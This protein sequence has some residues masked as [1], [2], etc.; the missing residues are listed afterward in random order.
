MPTLSWS[1]DFCGERFP[2]EAAAQWHEY[3]QCR[4]KLMHEL[5]EWRKTRGAEI[6]ELLRETDRQ[7]LERFLNGGETADRPGE[8]YNTP[9]YRAMQAHQL[10]KRKPPKRS[11]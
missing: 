6:G 2:T 1:C 7:G 5:K 8:G 9:E 10:R 3:G 11:A 4:A